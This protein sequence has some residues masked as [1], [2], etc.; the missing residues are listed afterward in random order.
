MCKMGAVSGLQPMHCP[1]CESQQ[2]VKNGKN[3]LQDNTVVQKYLCKACRK[4]FND[5][6]STPMARLRTP[7]TLV[8]LAMNDDLERLLIEGYRRLWLLQ[9]LRML[10]SVLLS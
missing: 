2:I 3:T 4:Q 1:E 6:T 7:S 5:R 10:G 9:A 8:T